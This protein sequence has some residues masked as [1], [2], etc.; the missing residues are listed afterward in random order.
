MSSDTPTIDSMNEVIAIFDGWEFHEGD[1]NHKCN[2]CFAGDEPCTPA[3]D[4]FTKNG[5]TRF[6]YNMKYNYSWDLLMPVVEKVET[7]DGRKYSV[8]IEKDMCTIRD[9]MADKDIIYEASPL[10]DLAASKIHATYTALYKFIQWYNQ[11][12]NQ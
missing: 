7:L 1:P 4:R 6:H 12:K 3:V 10:V 9:F 8:V 5:R 2:F 11:N